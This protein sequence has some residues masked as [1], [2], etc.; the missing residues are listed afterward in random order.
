[1]GNE[2]VFDLGLLDVG[3][4]PAQDLEA[5]IVMP[6]CVACKPNSGPRPD[7]K[8]SH[9]PYSAKAFY[10]MPADIKGFTLFL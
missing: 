9:F 2:G 3:G 5:R 1:M 6:Q 7:L 4:H 8:S 10:A